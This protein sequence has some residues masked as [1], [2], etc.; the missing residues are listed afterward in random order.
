M[1]KIYDF[2]IVGLGGAAGSMMRYG[3]TLLFAALG[4]PGTFATMSVSIAGSFVI[5]CLTAC[6]TDS[7]ALLFLTIGLCGGFTTF[8]TFSMQSV[9]LFQDGKF[10]PLILYVAGT[11]VLCIVLACLGYILGKNYLSERYG[12]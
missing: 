9:R 10:F 4:W 8:S 2:L 3:V 12:V 7:S 1:E 5:G 11:V 6:L